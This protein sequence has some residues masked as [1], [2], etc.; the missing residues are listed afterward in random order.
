MNYIYLAVAIVGEVAATTALKSCDGSGRVWP[1]AVV[2]IGYGTALGLLSLSLRTIPVGIAYAIWAGCGTV[3]VL[4]ASAV[5]H[6][7]IP[8]VP[9]LAGIALIAAGVA[10]TQSS[11]MHVAD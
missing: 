5:L 3:L 9:A 2:L 1:Y 7:Q 11:V 6:R 10:V 4:L 8:D